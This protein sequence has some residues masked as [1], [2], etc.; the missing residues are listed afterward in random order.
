MIEPTGLTG[1]ARGIEDPY[2]RKLAGIAFL[3]PD[4]QRQILGALAPENRQNLAVFVSPRTISCRMRR[5]PKNPVASEF[6][7]AS[8]TVGEPPE[9]GRQREAK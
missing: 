4:I 2:L 5:Y 8:E 6:P 3:A 7:S 1:D 9:T